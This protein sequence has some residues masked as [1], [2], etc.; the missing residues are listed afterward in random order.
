LFTID[1]LNRFDSSLRGIVTHKTISFASSRLL[2]SHN[3]YTDD[4]SEFISLKEV[5]EVEVAPFIGQVEYEK[6]SSSWSLFVLALS[7]AF[8]CTWT[9]LRIT[10]NFRSCLAYRCERFFLHR[11]V[12]AF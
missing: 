12:R 10:S 6:I 2:V 5:E 9:I 1:F 7:Y 8:D 4:G 11:R 3:P